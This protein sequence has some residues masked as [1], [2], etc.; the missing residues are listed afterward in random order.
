MASKYRWASCF[1]DGRRVAYSTEGSYEITENGEPMITEDGWNGESDGV[2]LT[3]MNLTR[4][5]PVGGD[6]LT[7]EETLL[8]RKYVK[9]TWASLNGK[10]F[11]SEMKIKTASFSGNHNSGA[12]NGTITAAGGKPEIVG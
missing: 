8:Q 5:C 3:S 9:I 10:I 1:V 2:I 6:G 7:L 11:T 4:A 12:Q